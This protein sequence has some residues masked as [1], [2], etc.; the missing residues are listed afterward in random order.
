MSKLKFHN[1][2]SRAR[3]EED[4]NWKLMYEN[5][6]DYLHPDYVH[7]LYPLKKCGKGIYTNNS[8]DKQYQ[9]INDILKKQDLKDLDI[10][11]LSYICSS[12]I[13]TDKKLWWN[14]NLGDVYRENEYVNFYLFPSTNFIS[15]AGSY[16]LRQTYQPNNPLNFNYELDAYLP[17]IKIMFK[18]APL[19]KRLIEL[20]INTIEEDS[21]ILSKVQKN[22][23]SQNSSSNMMHGD[24]EEQVI[25]NI[26]FINN[27][28]QEKI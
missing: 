22:Y 17:E 13:N 21:M 28:Y 5:V 10:K 19:L 6:K 24:Y 8:K 3:W 15:Y 1:Q 14:Q 7:P 26:S 23:L 27:I 18:T 9:D 4:F 11:D 16:F 12:N 2:M 25:K 20:E